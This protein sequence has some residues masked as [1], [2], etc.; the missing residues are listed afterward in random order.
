[1]YEAP[2]RYKRMIAA[3]LP[4][5]ESSAF[6]RDNDSG[7]SPL[8]D[9]QLIARGQLAPFFALANGVAAVL[10]TAA[11]WG[12]VPASWLLGW[13][14]AVGLLNYVAMRWSQSQAVSCVGRAGH[15][16]PTSLMIGDVLVR[17]AVWLSLPL[18]LFPTLD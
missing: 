5:G 4:D 2:D 14:G 18:Y 7:A 11:L 13:S 8:R 10:F 6:A 3:R 16:V 12:S 15:S 17:A 1:M 9:I